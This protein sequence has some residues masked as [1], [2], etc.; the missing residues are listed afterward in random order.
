MEAFLEQYLLSED[1]P[2]TV[3]FGGRDAE[4]ERLDHWLTDDQAAPRFLLAA[5]AGRGKSA[6]LVQWM[7]R[8]QM[9]GHVGKSEGSWRVVFFPISLRYSTNLPRVFYEALA[10]RLNEA[11]DGDLKPPAE[12]AD[13]AAYYE[14][15]CRRMLSIASGRNLSVLIIIDGIDEALG[16][17]LRR[18]GFRG[19]V[20]PNFAWWSPRA[21]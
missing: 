3:P 9:A 19:G 14:D 10:A 8:L 20:A 2:G 13:P 17:A 1:G 16:G 6:L 18:T 21:C 4:L 11:V 7:A 15:Q 12:G 5:P